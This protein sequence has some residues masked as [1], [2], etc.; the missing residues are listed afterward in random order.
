MNVSSPTA[1]TIPGVDA[2]QAA[3]TPPRHPAPLHLAPVGAK[4]VALDCDGGRLSSDAGLVLLQDPE[5]PLGLPHNLAAVLSDPRAPR[6]VHFPHHDLLQHRVLHMAAGEEEANDA[7]TLRHEPLCTLLLDRLPATGAPLASQPTRA[8]FANRV[9]RTGRSRM[10]RVWVDPWLASS[11]SPPHLIVLD[12]DDPEDPVPGAQAPARSEGSYGGSGGMPLHRYAGL[13]G[14]LITTLFQATRFPGAQRLAGLTRLVKRLRQ[15]WPHTRLLLRGDRHGAYPEVRQW[16]EE[17]P[18]RSEG[19]GWTSNRV[20]TAWAREG[21][22]PTKRAEEREGSTSTRVHSTPDQ[23]GTWSRSRRV[24]LQGEVSDPGVNTRLV[25]TDR[26]PARPQVLS[27][28]MDGA[29][30]HAEHALKDHPR[31]L[32]SERT[33]CPRFEA[34]PCRLFVH[35]AASGFLDTWRREVCTTTPWASATL[36][37]SHLRLL[38][39]GA[40]VPEGTERI[41]ISLPASC[42]VAPVW[43]RRLPW[44]ACGRL[45]EPGKVL[46]RS[47]ESV[48]GAG[49]QSVR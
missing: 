3:S 36:E 20:V 7:H 28:P 37:T 38:T 43:R 47:V 32:Q 22:E 14:R 2:L 19:T 24:V 10:A 48:E 34:T 18:A 8:R 16:I 13:S 45:A 26:E 9:S 40:R 29:R 46:G 33:A 41:K 27:P 39:L 11:V 49:T 42:P 4:A 23:A 15:A 35:S 44:L 1:Y 12:F 5:E 25:V 6:R 31:S 21:V 17:Q 30:G